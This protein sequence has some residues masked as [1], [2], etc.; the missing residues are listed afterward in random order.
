L[1]ERVSA[2]NADEQQWYAGQLDG[3]WNKPIT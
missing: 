3:L 1:R 2:I